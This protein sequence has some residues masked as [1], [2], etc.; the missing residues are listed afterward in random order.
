MTNIFD[1]LRNRIRSFRY[2]FSGLRDVLFTEHNAW[3]HAVFTI[4]GLS[5][6]LW[7]RISF[8]DFVLIVIVITLVWVAETFNTVL[9]ILVNM[10]SPRYTAVAKRAK[11]IAAAA[12]LVAAIG[13]FVV[14]LVLLGIPLLE[15]LG[16]S[17]G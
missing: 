11:D 12:V 14:G 15:R 13:A 8:V 2:A 7:L 17:F 4:L 16:F 5:L 10:V 1:F 6:A 3:I 9:E